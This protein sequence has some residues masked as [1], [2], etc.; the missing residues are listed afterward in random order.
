MPN[1]P[2]Q[3]KAVVLSTCTNQRE[4]Q[5]LPAV[6]LCL[7]MERIVN[8]LGPAAVGFQMEIDEIDR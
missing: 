2:P 8:Q 6:V 3:K 1:I 4:F 5:V 7:G